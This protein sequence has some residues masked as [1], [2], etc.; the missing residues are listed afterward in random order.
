MEKRITKSARKSILGMKRD[1]PIDEDD[2]FSLFNILNEHIKVFVTFPGAS[3]SKHNA[4]PAAD[5]SG[6]LGLRLI[7][8]HLIYS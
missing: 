2:G 5:N 1:V 7:S 8:S 6:P 4:K 3:T